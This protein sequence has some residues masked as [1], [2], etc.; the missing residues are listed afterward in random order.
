M[1]ADYTLDSNEYYNQQ[2]LK[3]HLHTPFE[4]FPRL[5]A[6]AF[7]QSESTAYRTNFSVST[8]SSD[9]SLAAKA[10][11]KSSCLQLLFHT[12]VN[13]VKCV[14]FHRFCRI[15]NMKGNSEGGGIYRQY[16]FSDKVNINL[17]LNPSLDFYRNVSIV[18]V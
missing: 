13:T 14:Y 15:R 11:V 8:N 2:H 9:I 12:Y 3:L 10:K 6:D 1:S 7:I 17:L 16:L 4:V 18:T 5:D